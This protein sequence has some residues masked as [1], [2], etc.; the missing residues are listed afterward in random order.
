MSWQ[1]GRILKKRDGTPRLD[2]LK[3]FRK[4]M[5]GQ[6]LQDIWTDIPRV[7]NV[8]AERLGLAWKDEGK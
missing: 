7:A 3:V 2:G 6:P 8:S 5:F 4:D 1:E